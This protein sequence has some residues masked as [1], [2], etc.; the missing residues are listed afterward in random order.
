VDIHGINVPMVG[1]MDTA[2]AQMCNNMIAVQKLSVEAAAEGNVQKLKQAMLLDPLVGAVLNPKQ[3]WQMTDEL[4]IAEE[5]WLPQFN[6]QA[7]ADAKKRIDAAKQNGTYFKP[8][9]TIKGGA[10]RE[11]ESPHYKP[12]WSMRR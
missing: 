9:P 8:D 2:M 1:E 3:I 6:K 5:S 10:L 7:F 4:M 12:D 11:G